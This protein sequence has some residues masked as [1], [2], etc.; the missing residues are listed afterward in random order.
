MRTPPR[1]PPPRAPRRSSRTPTGARASSSWT[2]PRLQIT[3]RPAVPEQDGAVHQGALT[4]QRFRGAA[5][6]LV[7]GQAP[8]ERLQHLHRHRRVR[9]EHAAEVAFAKDERMDGRLGGHGRRASLAREQRDLAEERAAPEAVDELPLPLD[10]RSPVDDDHEVARHAVALADERA[11]LAQVVLVGDRGDL[12]QVALGELREERDSLEE[13]DLGVPAEH[14]RDSAPA[15]RRRS[16]CSRRLAPWSRSSPPPTATTRCSTAAAAGAASSC[17]RSRSASGTTSARSARSRRA[18]RSSDAH[19]T[20]A[21]R[22]STSRT[23]TGRR[24][25]RPR[26]PSA[27]SSATTS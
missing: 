6:G 20:W 11:A 1:P 23:T 3:F 7:A 10:A 24:T 9:L 25:A 14:P 13:L 26:R 17:R 15:A 4:P 22:T 21:S 16:S 27:R 19:S 8:R 2:P 18:A 5:L 12:A